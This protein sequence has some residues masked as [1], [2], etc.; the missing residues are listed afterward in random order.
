MKKLFVLIRD[1]GDGSYS[2][3]YTMNEAWIEKMNEKSE[4]DEL[5]YDTIGVDGDGFHYDE[6]M[7]PDECTLESLKIYH[8]CAADD[9]D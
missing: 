9:E 1:N 2:P 5:D 8:D 6:L 4:N 7:V 3:C